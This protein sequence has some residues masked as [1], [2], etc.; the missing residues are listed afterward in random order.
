MDTPKDYLDLAKQYQKQGRWEEV[1]IPTNTK[2][3]FYSQVSREDMLT[4]KLTERQVDKL[5]WD[6]LIHLGWKIN[7]SWENKRRI[8]LPCPKC[9]L[10]ID[11]LDY[12]GLLL[13]D[14][15]SISKKKN[16]DG[17]LDT[18]NGEPCIPEAIPEGEEA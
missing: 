2:E 6:V 4:K 9:N 18:H 15:R 1:K 5:F 17:M 16:V 3:Q 13:K 11:D 14:A 7:M 12:D 10:I 8:V